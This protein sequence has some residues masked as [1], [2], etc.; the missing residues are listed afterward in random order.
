MTAS[1]PTIVNRKARFEYKIEETFEAGLVLT[2][3]EVK[4]LR[5]GKASIQE[6]YATI[7]KEEAWLINS[8]IEEYKQGTRYNHEPK[9]QRKL[10]LKRREIKKLI[11]A[12]KTKGVT[13][14]PLKLYFNQRGI[15]KL[16]L[17]LATGK[18]QHEKRDAIKERDWKREQ[19]RL[20]KK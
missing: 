4:S 2:G 13:L 18:K 10:L 19:A 20:L 12:L 3:T 16:Q 1:S 11:G 17:G 7:Y 5:L 6:A 8:T 9:R 14:I 15:A